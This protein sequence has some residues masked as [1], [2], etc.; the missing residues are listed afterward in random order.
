MP[1]KGLRERLKQQPYRETLALMQAAHEVR[2]G[3]WFS[4][5][6]SHV[7]AELAAAL[8]DHGFA[9][10]ALDSPPQEE[11]GEAVSRELPDSDLPTY[12]R[13]DLWEKRAL[14]AERR[15]DKARAF[16]VREVEVARRVDS[17]AHR[18]A[19]EESLAALDAA[20]STKEPLEPDC[21]RETEY[22]VVSADGQLSSSVWSSLEAADA[23]R[24]RSDAVWPAEAPHRIQQRVV[25]RSSWVDLPTDTRRRFR[26]LPTSQP[27]PKG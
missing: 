4:G 25:T 10:A 12:G 6:P 2:G 27:A 24:V 16:L 11:V 3:R 21:E 17:I 1:D 19:L 23:S 14:A 5:A 18:Q 15:V 8:N 26:E 7:F 13:T 9:V 22:R 20:L